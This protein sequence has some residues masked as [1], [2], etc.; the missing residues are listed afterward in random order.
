MA[1]ITIKTFLRKYKVVAHFLKSS[2]LRSLK[3]RW[4]CNPSWVVIKGRELALLRSHERE[5]A[6]FRPWRERE[7]G[8]ELLT[9]KSQQRGKE[10]KP[11]RYGNWHNLEPREET[12]GTGI[13]QTPE[14]GAVGTGIVRP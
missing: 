12:V 2:L 14:K 8:W 9:L 11:L 7:M 1:G 4:E 5:L 3:M 13:S 10:L 6:F